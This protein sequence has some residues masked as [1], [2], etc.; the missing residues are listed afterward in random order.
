MSIKRIEEITVDLASPEIKILRVHQFDVDSIQLTISCTE[1]GEEWLVPN[2]GV[3]AYFKAIKPDGTKYYTQQTISNG[4]IFVTFTEQLFLVDGTIYAEVELIQNSIILHTMPFRIIVVK[5]AFDNNEVVSE[6]ELTVITDMMLNL[7]NYD[8]AYHNCLDATEDAIAA[9]A[10]CDAA[11]ERVDEYINSDMSKEYA[12]RSKEYSEQSQSY[13]IQSQNYSNQ[14]K[15]YSE[16]AQQYVIDQTKECINEAKSWA[17]GTGDY[18]REAEN[19]YTE[20]TSVVSDMYDNSKYYA[21]VAKDFAERAHE[22]AVGPH[23]DFV[24]TTDKISHEFID[25]LF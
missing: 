13:S 3:D 7:Q 5:G 2:T 22:I 16:Q 24:L 6:D 17:V 9:I 20:Q 14:S 11:A 25:S 10:E 15:Q 21:K 19:I 12:N 18:T 8:T 4:K 1:H 23:T